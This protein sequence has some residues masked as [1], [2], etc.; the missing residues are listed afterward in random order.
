MLLDPE[1]RFDCAGCGQ[2][3]RTAWNIRVE[4][5]RAER[6]RTW[7]PALRILQDSGQAPLRRRADG[8]LRVAKQEGSC[9]FL[10]A[11]KGC[12]IHAD[13]GAQA[14]P[15]TCQIF[16]FILVPT[17]DGMQVGLS[18]YCPSV[19]KAEGRELQEHRVELERFVAEAGLAAL[20]GPFRLWA[21]HETGWAGYRQFEDELLRRLSLDQAARVLVSSC[22]GLGQNLDAWGRAEVQQ[23]FLPRRSAYS[24]EL[25]CS[26]ACS[27]VA[28]AELDDAE[29][30]LE[31][32]AALR[33]GQP[34]RLP[35]SNVQAVH[36]CQPVDC[37]RYLRSLVRRKFL[38]KQPSLL[39]GLALLS[40]VPMALSFYGPQTDSGV[41]RLEL[42]LSHGPG[43]AGLAEGLAASCCEA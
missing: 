8:S 30:A 35:G 41:E 1:G 24:Q 39:E 15:L 33:R 13:L 26:L 22:E 10:T 38:L 27:L 37:G 18:F 5:S 25:A 19:R 17:P 31:L 36:G 3:C 14:K 28:R 11:E 16:P 40:L 21:H 20:A 6:L 34:L 23:L 42:L 7:G 43:A 12:A 9:V 32:A 29:P 2:C 4:P